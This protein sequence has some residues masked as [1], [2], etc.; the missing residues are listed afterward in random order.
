MLPTHATHPKGGYLVEP[1]IIEMIERMRT[2]RF[3]V[4]EHLDDWFREFETYHR[5]NGKIVKRDDDLMSAT[6]MAVMMLRHACAPLEALLPPPP[7]ARPRD[8]A[9]LTWF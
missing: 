3:R 1:G 5:L 9:G 2:G 7:P 6:R 4:F 8:D